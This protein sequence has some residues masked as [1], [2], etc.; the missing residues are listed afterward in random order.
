MP[1]K[2]WVKRKLIISTK[3]KKIRVFSSIRTQ[4]KEFKRNPRKKYL[5]L[6]LPP[7]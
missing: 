7:K 1:F 2:L 5:M 3:I 6:S 4:E